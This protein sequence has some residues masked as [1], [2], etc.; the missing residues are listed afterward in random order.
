MLH[1]FFGEIAQYIYIFFN[2]K[3]CDECF[4]KKLLT[5]LW[6]E[7][8]LLGSYRAVSTSFIHCVFVFFKLFDQCLASV[9]SYCWS[10]RF[11][12][13]LDEEFCFL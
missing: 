2:P 6:S 10:K 8:L 1:R 9:W 11:V 13:V 5:K 4:L 12:F 3:A 7:F